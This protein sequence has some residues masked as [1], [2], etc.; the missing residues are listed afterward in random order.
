MVDQVIEE[1]ILEVKVHI[2]EED[3]QTEENKPIEGNIQETKAETLCSN[4]AKFAKNS[5]IW[6]RTVI[7]VTVRL[8]HNTMVVVEIV[9]FTVM[10]DNKADKEDKQIHLQIHL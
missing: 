6:Q 7:T 1:A 2:I 8:H 9:V 4:N 10:D 3:F 5:D